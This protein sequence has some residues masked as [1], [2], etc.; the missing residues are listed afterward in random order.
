MTFKEESNKRRSEIYEIYQ[1]FVQ[2]HLL[3]GKEK[4]S[5]PPEFTKA[6]QEQQ[7]RKE[8]DGGDSTQATAK[9]QN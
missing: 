7:Q 1:S 6:R 4:A 9:Q 3:Y 8:T 2:K 5:L